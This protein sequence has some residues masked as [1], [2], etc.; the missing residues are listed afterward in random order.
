MMGLCG[1]GPMMRIVVSDNTFAFVLCYK[2]PP[3]T[4][5][6][7]IEFG[8]VSNNSNGYSFNGRWNSL[9]IP[10]HIKEL[11][12]HLSMSLVQI[13]NQVTPNNRLYQYNRNSNRKWC[14]RPKCRTGLNSNKFNKCEMGNPKHQCICLG[15]SLFGFYEICFYNC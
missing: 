13:R 5:L 9:H 6:D 14:N 2:L 12:I 7:T 1:L 4:I 15:I 10:W 11:V 8:I 3:S